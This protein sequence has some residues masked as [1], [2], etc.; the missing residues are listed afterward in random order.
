MKITAGKAEASI[1]N[2]PGGV[3]AF[4]L[5]GPDSGLVAA[6]AKRLVAQ[7]VPDDKADPFNLVRLD[8]ED[9]R[10]TKGRLTDELTATTLMGGQRVLNCKGFGERER[11]DVEIA[12]DA[13]EKSDN[14][15]VISAGDLASSSKLRKLF[16]SRADC[17]AVPCYADEG[18]SL[19]DVIRDTLGKA[20]L[21]AD[22]DG[23]AA[24]S[25]ALGADRSQSM[26]E[27]EKLITYMGG[28]FTGERQIVREMDVAAIIA[29]AAPLQL[30]TYLYAVTNGDGLA[31][32]RALDRLLADGQAP[33]RL[34]N[35][36][37]NHLNR[38]VSVLTAGGN[39][40]HT[41]DNL[42]PPLFWKVKDRFIAQAKSMGETRALRAVKD[43]ATA[44]V[45]L[46]VSALPPALVLSR[47]TLRLCH[48]FGR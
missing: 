19:T 23:L 31:A 36:L 28:P 24:L 48:I 5:Y 45:D 35:A 33:I 26:A 22:R 41:V 13:A 14:R 40:E 21:E 37:T 38:F 47:L 18:R 27:L 11:A 6:R 43:L 30:D 8:P 4:L 25:V 39:V 10:G 44:G 34:H 32:D 16:E 17:L 7:I 9:L 42:R 46:R 3:R 2:P 29:D 20:G 12:L 1:A 15:L